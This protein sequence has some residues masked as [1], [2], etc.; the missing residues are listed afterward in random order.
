MKW[1]IMIIMVGLLALGCT[2]NVV[3]ENTIKIGAQLALT[4]DVAVYGIPMANGVNLAVDQL[5]ANGG[6][7]G[8]MIELVMEDSVC[9][10]KTA[11]IV[12][13]KLILVDKVSA[14]VGDLCSSSMLSAA[15]LAEENGV[16]MLSSSA[17]SPYIKDAGDYI[18]RNVAS[19][20]FQGKEGAKLANKLN[21][22]RVGIIAENTDYGIALS[23]VFTTEFEKFGGE[24]ITVEKYEQQKTKDFRTQVAKVLNNDI[25]GIYILGIGAPMVTLIKQI[26]EQ[27]S[28]VQLIGSEAMADQTFGELAEGLA[29]GLIATRP[30]TNDDEAFKVFSTDYKSKYNREPGVYVAESYDAIMVIAKAIEISDGSREGI[31]NALY[32]LGVYCGAS[33]CFEF[34][35]FGEVNG[36]TYEIVSYDSEGNLFVM[37]DVK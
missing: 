15:P 37:E 36:R 34:D 30:K 10:P 19:D 35:S 29:E 5:N 17:T 20:D 27:D 9:D 1:L 13:N 11:S 25:D 2:G 32:Q 28:E 7:N 12:A 4:G 6:I 8:K 31:K 3:K 24:V 16:V 18:F 23:K 21:V 14:I 26:K 33:G 22:K